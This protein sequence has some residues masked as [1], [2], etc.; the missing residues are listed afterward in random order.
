MDEKPLKQ[1]YAGE[2]NVSA[3]TYIVCNDRH[4]GDNEQQTRLLSRECNAVSAARG[5]APGE[6]AARPLLVLDETNSGTSQLL[7]KPRDV[8]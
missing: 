2:R 5:F 1:L 4:V 6:R 3:D 7:V 8:T